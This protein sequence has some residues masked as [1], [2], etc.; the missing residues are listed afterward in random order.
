M[1]SDGHS[2]WEH[3]H[4]ML[5]SLP[6][7]QL[8]R[9]PCVISTIIKRASLPLASVSKPERPHAV[10][11]DS[12]GHILDDMA[13][14]SEPGEELVCLWR[15]TQGQEQT[16]TLFRQASSAVPLVPTSTPP[17]NENKS[18]R[19]I[20]VVAERASGRANVADQ[21][22]QASQLAQT[23]PISADGLN[24]LVHLHLGST[25]LE[26]LASVIE[27]QT[28][29]HII[30][31]R[32]LRE[33]QMIVHIDGLSTRSA[34]DVLAMLNGWHITVFSRKSVQID[35]ATVFGVQQLSELPAVLNG[36]LPLD[37]RCYLHLPLNVLTSKAIN[38]DIYTDPVTGN[39]MDRGSARVLASGKA[40]Q[41]ALG[42]EKGLWEALSTQ[43]AG[44]KSTP[45]TQL[46]ARQQ[47]RLTSI[48]VLEGIAQIFL[49]G[50][51]GNDVLCGVLTPFQQ[52][53]TKANIT[54]E[55]TEIL[56]STVTVNAKTYTL[57][58]FSE[59]I[60]S[61]EKLPDPLHLGRR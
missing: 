61:P 47:E 48:V 26:H 49:F 38:N 50:S 58:A 29:V 23:T 4:D 24:A 39:Q 52:D 33:R 40:H 46:T 9:R 55:K 42:Y 35:R 3:L 25:T 14:H 1:F 17:S 13:V 51:R 12:Q 21:L 22:L 30:V 41:A 53:E 34:L 10:V 59:S 60:Q 15:D 16:L 37:F 7:A 28:G 56:V 57:Q 19:K 32:W 27:G 8:L 43:R 36:A 5:V 18:E 6:R 20:N 2:Q 31:P 54:V 11:K 45:Y 44:G